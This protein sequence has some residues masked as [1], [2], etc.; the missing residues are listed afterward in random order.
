MGVSIHYRGRLD[1]T[2]LL[3]S[4]RDEVSDIADTMGWPSTI[5]DNDWSIPPNAKLPPGGRIEGCLGLKGIQITPHPESEPLALFFDRDGY[6]RS[7]MTMLSILDG[8]LKPE[9]AWVTVKTQFSGPDTHVWVTGL[10]KYLKKR[11]ISDLEVRDEG[12]YWETGD[13]DVLEQ[14]MALLDDKLQHLSSDLSSGRMGDLTGLSAEQIASRIE[15]LLM[16]DKRT[17][18][19]DEPGN[20]T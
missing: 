1:D 9:N 5:L 20:D 4:L 16:R 13:R 7:P 11:Y 2:G 14:K 12:R 10:L 19:E 15:Q 18:A 8:T 3:P 6:L 17:D